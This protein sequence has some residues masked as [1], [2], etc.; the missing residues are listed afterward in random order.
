MLKRLNEKYNQFVTRVIILC[1][2][3]AVTPINVPIILFLNLM[4]AFMSCSVNV[5]LFHG[6]IKCSLIVVSDQFRITENP[7]IKEK[8]VERKV[9]G[10]FQTIVDLTLIFIHCITFVFVF[11][12][13]EKKM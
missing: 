12:S 4:V 7:K 9:S 3:E 10:I 1:I 2:K 13:G 8:G 11:K 6:G 5:L